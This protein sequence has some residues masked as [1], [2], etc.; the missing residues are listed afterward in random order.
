MAKLG[1]FLFLFFALLLLV[2]FVLGSLYV[3]KSAFGL[4]IAPGF[5]LGVWDNIQSSVDGL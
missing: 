5:S 4:N 3:L 1:N 2:C